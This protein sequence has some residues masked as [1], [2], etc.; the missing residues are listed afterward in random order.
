MAEELNEV[1]DQLEKER[2]LV[3]KVKAEHSASVEQLN[4]QV[5]HINDEKLELEKNRVEAQRRI[6]ALKT[7]FKSVLTDKD[8][9]IDSLQQSNVDLQRQVSESNTQLRNVTV[10]L[11]DSEE[12]VNSLQADLSRELNVHT[13]ELETFERLND[14][15][16][17]TSSQ[18]QK[19]EST[20]QHLE[21]KLVELETTNTKI[22]VVVEDLTRSKASVEEKCR[23][24]EQEYEEKVNELD[25]ISQVLEQ[26]ESEL[27]INTSIT[28]DMKSSVSVLEGEN[29]SLLSE[30]DSLKQLVAQRENE[31]KALSSQ[32]GKLAHDLGILQ[33]AHLETTNAANAK[34]TQ[35]ETLK[36]ELENLQIKQSDLEASLEKS[37][38]SLSDAKKQETLAKKKLV[39]LKQDLTSSYEVK[40]E[41]LNDTLMDSEQSNQELKTQLSA[42]TAEL[43][44]QCIKQISVYA[45]DNCY[46]LYVARHAYDPVILNDSN[47]SLSLSPAKSCDRSGADSALSA[48]EK[49]SDISVN[50]GD[51]VFVSGGLT[52]EGYYEGHL[53]DGRAGL[54]PSNVLEPLYEFDIYGF[55][56]ASEPLE[57]ADES[58]KDM[59][60]FSSTMFNDS[61][62][63]PSTPRP[64][65]PYPRNLVLD[66]QLAN[67]IL[68]GW[69]APEGIIS[70]PVTLIVIDV[71]TMFGDISFSFCS[72]S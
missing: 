8:G 38:H 45:G 46:H 1:K 24:L 15:L 10:K 42:M 66:K 40:I 43:E 35:Y 37:K 34:Q 27:E 65:A 5:Q 19:S 51:Y 36:Q 11:K 72:L 44:E 30:L 18:L 29:Q 6:E 58:R 2:K 13:N 71:E 54:I 31:K 56:I 50:P 32:I 63:L 61:S 67:G 39:S 22:Q 25:E 26:R 33:S 60:E 69:E 3:S 55:V 12:Q 59:S 21:S 49:I 64:Q 70:V 57:D 14:R 23:E 7:D 48:T 20:N 17:T 28:Q 4:G 62:V 16:N 41:K 53:L 52:E 47:D 9:E 68:V